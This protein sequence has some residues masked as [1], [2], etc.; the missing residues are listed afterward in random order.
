MSE[1]ELMQV[2]QMLRL[3]AG[4]N[5]IAEAGSI[6]SLPAAQARDLVARGHAVAF[7]PETAIVDP[8]TQ[9]PQPWLHRDDFGAW[10]DNRGNRVDPARWIAPKAQRGESE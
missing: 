4:P 2:V 8:W 10:R 7:D 9:T 6:V 3:M 5:G 1:T